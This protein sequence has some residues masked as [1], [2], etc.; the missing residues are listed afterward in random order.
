MLILRRTK[1]L[2]AHR[3]LELIRFRFGR[4]SGVRGRL[5]LALAPRDLSVGPHDGEGGAAARHLL[6]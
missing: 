5:L 1:A 6:L 4:H 2:L 3:R